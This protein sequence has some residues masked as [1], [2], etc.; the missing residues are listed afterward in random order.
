MH[1]KTGKGST[2][3]VLSGSSARVK[4]WTG[5]P[6]KPV[7]MR[8]VGRNRGVVMWPVVHSDDHD[9]NVMW[10]DCDTCDDLLDDIIEDEDDD[11]A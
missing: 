9:P 8:P 4:R 5:P 7:L 10:F 11:L 2:T 1:R 6:V 3:N